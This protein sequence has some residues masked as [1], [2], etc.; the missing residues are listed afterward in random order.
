VVVPG[1]SLD[2]G[3]LVGGSVTGSFWPV[4]LGAG[5]WFCAPVSSA[6]A[7]PGLLATAKPTPSATA[8]APTRPT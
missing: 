8:N 3:V 4:A 7:A 1:G 5:S 6:S 2:G